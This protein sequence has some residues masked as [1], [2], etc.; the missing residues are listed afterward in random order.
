LR[1]RK[2]EKISRIIVDGYG[3][4]QNIKEIFSK[5]LANKRCPQPTDHSHSHD[6][7]HA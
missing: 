4:R 5:K 7:G 6:H 2:G 1:R 3:I